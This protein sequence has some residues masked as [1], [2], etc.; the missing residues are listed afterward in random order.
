MDI[1]IQRTFGVG[2]IIITIVLLYLVI[3]GKDG[4]A[5]ALASGFAGGMAASLGIANSLVIHPEIAI[6]QI[7]RAH[8]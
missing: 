1:W 8:V 6:A 2:L 4:Q 5:F 7:G 3:V